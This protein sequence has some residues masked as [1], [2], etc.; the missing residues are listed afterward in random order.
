MSITEV[1]LP[2]NTQAPSTDI[3]A[4]VEL[5]RRV[6]RL[7]EKRQERQRRSVRM[8]KEFAA[9]NRYL[10]IGAQVTEAL[11]ALSR[12]LF[13]RLLQIVE[14]K[15]SIALVEIIEQPLKFH[16]DA[17]FKRGGATVEFRIE[18]DGNSEDVLRGQ[19]GSVANVLSVG[20]RMF[21]L[22]TLDEAQHRRFLVLDEQDCWLRPDLVPRL[23][24]IVREAGQ[25][26]GFQV[27]M[28]SHHDVAIFERYADRIYE[29]SPRGDDGVAV[30]ESARR[31]ANRTQ[32]LDHFVFVGWLADSSN[33]PLR[34]ACPRLAGM[35]RRAKPTCL[36]A[37]SM[38]PKHCSRNCH[39]SARWRSAAYIWMMPRCSAIVTAWVRS[40]ACSLARIFCT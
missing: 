8:A 12:E 5:R 22:M 3:S 39:A 4:P 21:A 2:A 29:F 13:K 40:V 37:E 28:I 38:P 35:N 7:L 16:A 6:D 10:G 24:K 23:V 11:D 26:L 20:L 34:V 9:L 36:R 1:S 27:L 15:L 33:P 18:R 32:R 19:G 31:R 14:E 25:A 30:R 17:D